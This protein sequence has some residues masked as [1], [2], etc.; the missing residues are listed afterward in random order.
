[1]LCMKKYKKKKKSSHGETLVSIKN[2]GDK[3][4]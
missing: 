2:K 1:M 3:Q 4:I